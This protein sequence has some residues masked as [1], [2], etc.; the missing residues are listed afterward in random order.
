LVDLG[1]ESRIVR[2]Q[3]R[4]ST[5][6]RR[7]G[8]GIGVLERDGAELDENALSDPGILSHGRL[9]ILR[10]MVDNRVED[11]R[12]P[13]TRRRIAEKRVNKTCL[14]RQTLAS[15]PPRRAGWPVP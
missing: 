2:V 1:S 3:L 13:Q 7:S 6:K 15:P 11:V 8:L 5:P 10:G 12:L 4:G 9:I 14:A